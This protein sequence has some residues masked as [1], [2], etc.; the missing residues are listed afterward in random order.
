MRQLRFVRAL[1]DGQLLVLESS[2]PVEQFA[3][4]ATEVSAFT[5]AAPPPVAAPAPARPAAPVASGPEPGLNPREVQMRVRAGEAPADVAASIGT[6]LERVMRF[7]GPVMDER[8][9]IAGEARRARARR[10]NHEGADNPVVQFGEAVDQRFAAHG[11]TATDVSWDARRREDGEWLVIARWV[12]GE[13]Q[14]SAEWLFHRTTR[15]VTPVDDTAT[16]LLSDRPVRPMLP[17]EP[18]RPALVAAPPLVPGIVAFPPMPEASTGP[19]PR[20][21]EVFD[22][23]APPEGPREVPP[24]V[25]ATTDLAFDEPPLPLGIVDPAQRPAAVLARLA[26]RSAAKRDETDD[27]RA[28]RARVP[29]WDDILLGVRRKQD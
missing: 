20:V 5:P 6:S 14:H 28:A 10:T 29:S 16:D 22:Q 13:S 19:I 1:G 24:L 4:P 15:S 12:G 18:E 27:E 2:D 23:D 25:P 17:P 9:R 8:V 7:A 26:N 21:E 3:L 11:I